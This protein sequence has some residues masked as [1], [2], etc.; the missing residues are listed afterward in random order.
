MMKKIAIIS[1]CLLLLGVSIA[2]AAPG[3]RQ[4][5]TQTTTLNS[6]GIFEGVVSP[7]RG[8]NATI[9]GTISGNYTLR[10]RGGRF[11]GDW[12]TENRTGTFRG[13]FGKHI[14]IGRISIMVNGTERKLPIVGFIQAQ[15]D[16]QFN[17]RFMAPVGPALYFR[18]TYT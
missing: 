3:M 17:G 6:T 7:R 4:Q 13:G 1:L 8:E 11:T 18:G 15:D 10:N 14:I 12:T 16:G 5:T 2:A 9:V